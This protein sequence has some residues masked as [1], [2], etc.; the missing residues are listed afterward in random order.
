MLPITLSLYFTSEGAN[1]PSQIKYIR[2][3]FRARAREKKQI[4]DAYRTLEGVRK[5]YV[6]LYTK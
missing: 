2:E 6:K 5:Q 3:F 4:R 1:L